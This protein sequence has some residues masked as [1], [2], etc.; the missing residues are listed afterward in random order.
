VL[1]VLAALICS[2]SCASWKSVE[3][4]QPSDPFERVEMTIGVNIDHLREVLLARS[5]GQHFS[6]EIVNRFPDL[7]AFLIVGAERDLFLDD[8]S[9]R[10]NFDRSPWM[11]RYLDMGPAERARDLYLL[12]VMDLFWASD[13]QYEGKPAKFY[14][15][16]L[17]HLEPVSADATRVEVYEYLPRIWVGKSFQ[18]GAHGPCMCRD[19]RWVE[20]TKTDRVAL[21]D[22]IKKAVLGA[23]Q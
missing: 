6:E 19:Q 3:K 9:I 22:A 16:F 20:Q 12:S 2:W 14:T 5:S 4:S 11:E 21:L 10:V 15:D 13:Y 8:G 18:L 23:A 7:D 17:L 1:I